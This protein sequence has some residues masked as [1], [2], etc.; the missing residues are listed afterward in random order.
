M[1]KNNGNGTE[2]TAA[3]QP[4]VH[5]VLQGKGGIGKSVV[6]SWLAEFLPLR[7]QKAS[8]IDADPVNRS[9]SQYKALGAEKLDLMNQDGLI[10]RSRYDHLLDRFATENTT[11]VV[12][13]GAHGFL[14]FCT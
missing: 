14:L 6:A 12:D 10:E 3:A 5:L 4:T 11:F 9:F 8:A 7:G 2:S 1:G 13:S